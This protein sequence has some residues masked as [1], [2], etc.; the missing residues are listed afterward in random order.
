LAEALRGNGDRAYQY[1]TETAPAYMNDQA[2][3]RKVEPYVH[4]Q[5]VESVDSPF[6]GRGHVH[7]LSGTAA[8][9]MVG[10]IEGILG[11]RPDLN[12]ITIGPA[13]PGEWDEMTMERTFRKKKLNIKVE[14]KNKSSSVCE[15]ILNGQKMV[16][17]HIP[18]D[19]LEDVNEITVIM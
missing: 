16:G 14:N 5:F 17:D 6:E 9:Y 8:T 7:W 13:I 4:C 18:A 3:I 19:M 10:C 11:L 15:L 2:E 12:G 1:F